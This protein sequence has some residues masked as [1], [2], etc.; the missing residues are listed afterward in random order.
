M[1]VKKDIKNE[2]FKRRELEIVLEEK[3]NPSFVDIQK[4]VSEKFKIPEENIQVLNIGNSFGRQIFDISVHI[5]DSKQKLDE[6][7]NLS[8]TKKARKEEKTAREEESKKAKE[9]KDAEKT[10]SVEKKENKEESASA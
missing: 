7:K 1:E 9:A 3:S 4:K 5:Y 10:A 8:K 2:L 6:I